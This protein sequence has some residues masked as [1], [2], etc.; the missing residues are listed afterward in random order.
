MS[1]LTPE[2]LVEEMVKEY[3]KKHYFEL[4]ES[5]LI[6]ERLYLG[7]A[8]RVVLKA[9][10]DCEVVEPSRMICSDCKVKFELKNSYQK[11]LES[12]A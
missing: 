6:Y 8:M 2:M 9:I 3:H 10:Q 12:G 11:F 1:E 5:D 7:Q 4:N